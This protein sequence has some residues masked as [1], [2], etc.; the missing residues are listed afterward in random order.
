MTC[1]KSITNRLSIATRYSSAQSAAIRRLR[2]AIGWA[3]VARSGVD[4]VFGMSVACRGL[5]RA[6]R[7]APSARWS[8]HLLA[9]RWHERYSGPDVVSREPGAF[10]V[11]FLRLVAGLGD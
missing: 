3:R 6:R 2:C 4:W 8:S 1:K 7:V 5:D 9:G 10:R 11:G